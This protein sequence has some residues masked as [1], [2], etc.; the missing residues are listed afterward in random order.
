MHMR[1]L[2]DGLAR[3][4]DLLEAQL[5]DVRLEDD[6]SFITVFGSKTK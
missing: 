3:H 1:V 6:Q 4:D 5:G 2:A